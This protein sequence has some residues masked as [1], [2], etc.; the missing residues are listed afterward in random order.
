MFRKRSFSTHNVYR[1][2]KKSS[3]P[4]ILIFILIALVLLVCGF[5]FLQRYVVYTSNGFHFDF[6]FL[7]R[8]EPAQTQKP[9]TKPADDA[10]TKP[11]KTETP[12]VTPP[13]KP[14]AQPV[15]MKAMEAD[16]SQIVQE[17]VRSALIAK[18]KALGCNTVT[19]AIK[20]QNG[21]V[22][23]PTTSEYAGQVSAAAPVNGAAEALSALKAA[24]LS[25]IAVIDV[26]R[27]DIAPRALRD[28]A[29]RTASGAVW[30]DRRNIA[31]LAPSSATTRDYLAQLIADCKTAGF[32]GAVLEALQYPSLG[33][34]SLIVTD[35]DADRFAAVSSLAAAAK[36]A[37]GD[38]FSISVALTESAASSLKDEA[39]A[40]DV[41][42]LSKSCD[43]LIA[44]APSDSVL[45]ALKTAA[46]AQNTGCAVISRQ[47][48]ANLTAAP[49]DSILT[50]VPIA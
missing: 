5:F 32:D 6:P 50:G 11:D 7:N 14:A 26:C 16:L 40:Q 8:E 25:P 21:K 15:A 30:L 23:I 4:K 36:T 22:L 27:D 47:P 19:L 49:S 31:W 38:S 42:A 13:E 12:A 45:Q 44:D 33:K 17:N 39:S 24:D 34:T 9:A 35:R 48:G 3:F 37:A 1:G 29:L 46:Q 10:S 41:A 20:T 28:A 18:A 43:A 2:R